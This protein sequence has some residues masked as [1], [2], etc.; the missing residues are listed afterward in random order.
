LEGVGFA[1][2]GEPGSSA[3]PGILSERQTL[4]SGPPDRRSQRPTGSGLPT[5]LIARTKDPELDS[6]NCRYPTRKQESARR[7]RARRRRRGS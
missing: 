5:R 7:R 1:G 2:G 4:G 3:I 6:P